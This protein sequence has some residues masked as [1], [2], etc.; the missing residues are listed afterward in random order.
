[1]VTGKRR[2]LALRCPSEEV[3]P[4]ISF[5][6]GDFTDWNLSCRELGHPQLGRWLER[7]FKQAQL[8]LFSALSQYRG[9]AAFAVSITGIAPPNTPRMSSVDGVH[10]SSSV[11]ASYLLL[12]YYSSNCLARH[13]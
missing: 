1:M 11:S 10:Q 9:A 6:D 2:D 7:L 13:S 12:A 8:W 4:D 3:T 5:R